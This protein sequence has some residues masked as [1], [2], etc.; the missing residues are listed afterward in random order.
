M[1][2]MSVGRIFLLLF[3][4]TAC[5]LFFY[6]LAV[7]KDH[8]VWYSETGFEPDE[9]AIVQ[10]ETVVFRNKT[11]IPFWPASNIHPSHEEYPSFDPRRAIGPGDSW[12]FVFNSTGEWQYHNHLGS[13]YS[14]DTGTIIVYEKGASRPELMNLTIDD[15]GK[16]TSYSRQRCWI[17]MLRST[18]KEQGTKSAFALLDKLYTEDVNFGG[19]CNDI[20]HRIGGQAWSLYKD[21]LTDIVSPETLFCNAGFYHGL[22]EVFISHGKNIEKAVAFCGDVNDILGSYSRLG[23]NAC[24]HGVGHGVMELVGVHSLANWNSINELLSQGFDVCTRFEDEYA[25]SCI[26]GMFN[27]V[28]THYRDTPYKPQEY[29][30]NPFWFCPGVVSRWQRFCYEAMGAN[31][32]WEG[33]HDIAKS[34]V[35]IANLVPPDHRQWALR[36]VIQ[37][38]AFSSVTESNWDEYIKACLGLSGSLITLCTETFIEGLTDNGPPGKEFSPAVTFCESMLFTQE[39]RDACM[40]HLVMYTLRLYPAGDPEGTCNKFDER[41]RSFCVK[42]PQ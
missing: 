4:V 6:N 33:K 39:K 23:V 12:E 41:Y 26:N 8:V 18:Q 31:M 10:G 1:S 13:N 20:T 24:F 40:K 7:P 21:H 25:T 30:D 17:R 9:F 28:F 16:L 35:F 27:A 11:A 34:S 2:R 36:T 5:G 22:M 15:C 3:G 29:A 19:T 42:K 38:T 14:P 32:L 37:E